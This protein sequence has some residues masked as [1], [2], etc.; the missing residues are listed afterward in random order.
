MIEIF[1]DYAFVRP[2]GR[3]NYPLQDIFN[4]KIAVLQDLRTET[5]KLSFDSLLVWWEGET[6][7]IPLP[8]NV[9]KGDKLYRERAPVFASSGGKLRIPLEEA[10]RMRVNPDRQNDMMDARW[11]YFCHTVSLPEDQSKKC[12]PCGR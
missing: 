1:G 10:I 5:Y 7:R 3:G 6:F 12:E 4:K 8:Q 9:N 2:V 11:R